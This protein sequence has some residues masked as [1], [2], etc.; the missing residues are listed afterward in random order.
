M[1][2]L[3]KLDNMNEIK[4]RNK[5]DVWG[6]ALT[7]AF[8]LMVLNMTACSSYEYLK[9]PVPHELTGKCWNFDRINRKAKGKEICSLP[10]P[11][12]VRWICTRIEGHGGLHHAHRANPPSCKW[13]W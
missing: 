9:E 5:K 7:I 4:L 2:G 10:A 11:Y 6:I 8:G 1:W 13:T 12:R 3:N